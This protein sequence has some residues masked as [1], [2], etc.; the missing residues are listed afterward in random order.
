MN[1]PVSR[2]E[3]EWRESQCHLDQI[4]D[5]RMFYENDVR[6][7]EAIQIKYLIGINSTMKPA[8]L[9]KT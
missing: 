6:F 2:S 3:W 8:K 7:L 9:Q 1:T 4:G 5:T